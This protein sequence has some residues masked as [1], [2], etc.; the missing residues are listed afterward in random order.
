MGRAAQFGWRR[1]ILRVAILGVALTPL[2]VSAAAPGPGVAAATVPPVTANLQLWFEADTTAGADGSPVTSWP[3]KSG[4]ARDLTAASTSAAPTMRRNVV[5]G[6]S[7]IEFNGVNSLMKTYNS[8]FTLSQPNTFF[9]VYRSLDDNSSNR[10]F[11]FDS[12]N[13]GVRQVLGKSGA[14]LLREYAN[15]DLDTGGITYPFSAFKIYDGVFNGANSNLF[16]NGTLLAQGNAGG[17][18]LDGFTVGGLNSAGTSGYDLSH[19]LVA[20]ILYY[21]GVLSATDRQAVADWLNEKYNVTGPPTLPSNTTPPSISGTTLDGSTLTASP[22]VWTGTLPITYAYQWQHCDTSGNACAN[23]TGS[24][25]TTYVLGPGDIG[26]TLRVVVT[27]SNSVGNV[28][29]TSG[30]TSV[31]L[32]APPVNTAPPQIS[33]SAVEGSTLHAS[34]GTWSGTAPITYTYLW[35]RCDNTGAGCADT[36]TTAAD[37]L[38]TSADV[39]STL[40]V[41]VTGTNGNGH[42]SA[43]SAAS[44]VISSAGSG[45][46]PAQPPV[47][48]GM[49]LWFEANTQAVGDGQS[50]M[51][52]PD[53]SGNGRNLTA[54]SATAAPTMRR[55]VLNGRNAIEFNGVNSLMKTYN[56]TFTIA[57]PDTFFIVYRALDTATAGKEAYVFDSANSSVRQLLGLGPFQ[58]TEMYANTDI[59]APTPYPFPNYQ[60]WSGTYNGASSTIWRNG[61]LI[62]SGYVGGSNMAGFTVGGLSSVGVDGYLLSHSLVAEILFYNGAMTASDRQAITDWLNLKYNVT[63]PVVPPSNTAP[64]TLSGTARDGSTLTV[65]NGSWSGTAP[66][67]FTYQWHR[68]NSTGGACSDIGGATAST[69]VA[70]STDVG[71]TLKVTVTA[72]NTAGSA[73]ADAGPSAVVAA[74]APANLTAPTISGLAR[75]G[76]T[77]TA[78][79][80]TWSGTTPLTFDYTWLRCDSNG[81]NCSTVGANSQTYVLVTDDVASTIEV[82][83]RASNTAGNASATSA[84]TAVV[85][86]AGSPPPP[87]SPP[88]TTGLQLWFEADTTTGVDGAA[89][90]SWPDKSGFGR[91]LSAASSSAAPTMRRNAV[92]GRAALEFNGT[93]SLMKTYSST[94]TLS[95]PNTF[96]I[97]YRS[98]DAN[99][100]SR[101]FVFD[102]RNSS[103][104]QVFGK[105]GLGDVRLYANNDLPAPTVTYPF[106]GYKIYAGVFNGTTSGLYENGAQLVQGNAGGSALTGLTVGGLNSSGNDGYDLTHSLVA[107]ILYYNGVLS[108][109]DR[110]AVASWLNTKYAAY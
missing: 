51:S 52:W 13:S 84:P 67:A 22:G 29:A 65:S 77:L 109:S 94:F 36:T 106:A 61:S 48:A 59:E 49:Q 19:S 8:T 27:A 10:A 26:T 41:V 54:A 53:Q 44:L 56:S 93:T 103:V 24:T 80:G 63:A 38:L 46:A 99:T 18:A 108:A 30:A 78:A 95:Q 62:T 37:Y 104:R 57:Q 17:S 97:V 101:A 89:V 50:V 31:V 35:R 28:T 3:D 105:G 85:A 7:A 42:A 86:P 39:G 15:A 72:S 92:N 16:E 102:S 20:E 9:I 43:T 96:F 58:N 82:R 88:V 6:R 5:N 91:D 45:G 14:G 4:L 21:N 68:C 40:R 90:T 47:T 69:F 60:I 98:L 11:V 55:A 71:S 66:F 2:L 74:A 25:G 110:S 107:E 76:S 70:T 73:S 12:R 33:G 23:I 1:T 75:E 81:A 32:A 64:P 87:G 34:V 83:V 100:S 79:N